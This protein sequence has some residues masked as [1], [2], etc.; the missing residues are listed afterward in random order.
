M[1]LMDSYNQ[2][3]HSKIRIQCFTLLLVDLTTGRRTESGID[4]VVPY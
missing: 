3:C 2:P 1:L 4:A